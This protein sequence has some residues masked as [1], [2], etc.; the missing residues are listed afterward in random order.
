MPLHETFLDAHPAALTL[1]VGTLVAGALAEWLV[2]FRERL[3]TEGGPRGRLAARTFVEA[4][5]TRTD[6]HQE[7]DRGTKRVLVVGMI[8]GL[9]AGWLAARYVPG[10]D[11]PG[12]GWLWVTLGVLVMLAGFALRIVSI[13]VLGRFFRRD[14]TV[15]EGQSVVRRGPYRYLRHPAYAGNLLVALGFGIALANW[16]SIAALAVIPLLCHLPRIRV[17][18]TA[19]EEALGKPYRDYE[20][21]TARLVPGLW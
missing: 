21:E 4:T 12:S 14:V 3:A 7:S 16:L 9:F 1:V 19:L 2:T 6:A 13:A 17:E 11:L 18:E 5:T 8:A 15:E 10:A 20:E